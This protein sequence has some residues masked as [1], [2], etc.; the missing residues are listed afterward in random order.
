MFRRQWTGGKIWS[1]WLQSQC[2]DAALFLPPFFILVVCRKSWTCWRRAR[3]TFLWT[4]SSTQPALWTSNT[5]V[6]P[7]HLAED[8]VG[9]FVQY[10]CIC[11]KLFLAG[12]LQD[13]KELRLTNVWV[14]GAFIFLTVFC[15]LPLNHPEMSCLMEALQDKRV[16]LQP[17]CKKRLQD[18]ID[19][20]SYAAKVS[21]FNYR[22][23]CIVAHQLT[24]ID[25][26]YKLA[27]N[28][29]VCHICCYVF[30]IRNYYKKAMMS[31]MMLW[32]SVGSWELLSS[33]LNGAGSRRQSSITCEQSKQRWTILSS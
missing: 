11:T 13:V 23:I 27:L 28:C 21:M 1:D 12:L 18:R 6:P 19:M 32:G 16:R 26:I 4:Q 29:T 2:R 22:F 31:S 9:D 10:I 8:D 20:W 25:N 30:L 14:A 33:L 24:L 15:F 5:T 17:E 7:S 3:L